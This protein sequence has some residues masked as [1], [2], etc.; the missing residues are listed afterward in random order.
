M[1]KG[2]KEFGYSLHHLNEKLDEGDRI[3]VH[4]KPLDYNK[5]MLANMESRYEV[6]LTW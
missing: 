3:D 5:I 6:L 2:E 4:T 1:M